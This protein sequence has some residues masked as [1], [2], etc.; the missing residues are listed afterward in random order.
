[1][2]ID[3]ITLWLSILW[4][5]ASQ[6]AGAALVFAPLTVL[7][8]FRT[9]ADLAGE[10]A[11]HDMLIALDYAMTAIFIGL[12]T[13]AWYMLIRSNY[14]VAIVL[15]FISLIPGVTLFILMNMR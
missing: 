12:G 3:F 10:L 6:V 7:L 2:S 9:Q 1:M 11:T 8:N 13:F 14:F 4:L 15:G 5:L